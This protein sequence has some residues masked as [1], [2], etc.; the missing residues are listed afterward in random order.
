MTRLRNKKMDK[1]LML[2]GHIGQCDFNL[3][4]HGLKYVMCKS[5][6][7]IICE[8]T[9]STND[10]LLITTE[11]NAVSY[12]TVSDADMQKVCSRGYVNEEE[13]LL[14]CSTHRDIRF[15]KMSCKYHDI[16]IPNQLP[17]ILI[18]A[19]RGSRR[20]NHKVLRSGART[21]KAIVSKRR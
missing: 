4:K 7:M 11:T 17:C 13:W 10:R 5:N 3:Q 6:T 18:K 2:T 19:S 9:C 21:H 15:Q 16:E 14:F 12:H 20:L 1:T 8:I